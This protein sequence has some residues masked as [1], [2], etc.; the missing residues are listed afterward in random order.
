MGPVHIE[1]RRSIG[2]GRLRGVS[3]DSAV[4]L[5]SPVYDHEAMIS[6][7]DRQI[8]VGD[9]VM[10]WNPVTG[11]ANLARVSGRSMRTAP[12]AMRLTMADGDG[13]RQHRARQTPLS[14]KIA[15][16]NEL[17]YYPESA[18]MHVKE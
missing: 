11:T 6:A 16:F 5:V 1:R 12:Y 13:K 9:E 10:A 7:P 4:V 2:G 3:D 17:I 8:A 14:A 18:F 15:F